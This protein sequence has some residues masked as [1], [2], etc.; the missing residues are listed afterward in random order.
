[1]VRRRLLC[2]VGLCLMPWTLR[3]QQSNPE[4]AASYRAALHLVVDSLRRVIGHRFE[5]SK[6]VGIV[7]DFEQKMSGAPQLPAEW[8]PANAAQLV[9]P[10]ALGPAWTWL[11]CWTRKR[12]VAFAC[13][14]ERTALLSR[15]R[16]R[17]VSGGHLH[18][19]AELS[20][21]VSAEVLDGRSPAPSW[22]GASWIDVSVELE[23]SNAR[24]R[25]VKLSVVQMSAG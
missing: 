3:A 23:Q 24:W 19:F 22:S 5:Y 18:V 1:M 6:A 4:E 15:I 25:I 14:V 17:P 8:M 13:P 12:A 10:E 11:V 16:I 7:L 20:L 9:G 2:I 21:P